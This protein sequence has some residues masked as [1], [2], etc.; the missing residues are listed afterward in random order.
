MKDIRVELLIILKVKV[1]KPSWDEMDV[2]MM[3]PFDIFNYFCNLN[4]GKMQSTMK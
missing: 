2:V 1:E 3:C 4:G